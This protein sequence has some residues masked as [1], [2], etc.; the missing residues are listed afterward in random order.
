MNLIKISL[1][2]IGVHAKCI[3]LDVHAS[4]AVVMSEVHLPLCLAVGAALFLDFLL[5]TMVIPIFPSMLPKRE[6][7]AGILFAAKPLAQVACNPLAAWLDNVV[8]LR[9][10]T[11]L[12][13]VG[14]LAF[15]VAHGFC[16]LVAIR[17]A[18]GAAS[19]GVM[20]GGMSL[21]LSSHAE[22]ARPQAV[23]R[24]LLGLT[25]GVCLGPVWGGA[26]YSALGRARAFGLTSLAMFAVAAAQRTLLMGQLRGTPVEQEPTDEA[27]V[28]ERLAGN[29]GGRRTSTFRVCDTRL[30]AASAAML[31][32]SAQ[33][34]ALEV[35]TTYSLHRRFHLE[36]AQR[37]LL[38]AF[39]V[40]GCHA[41][42]TAFVA[43]ADRRC[44]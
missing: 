4:G 27:D 36:T 40:P 8:A 37:G 35:V 24:A 44:R 26:A 17:V 5:V 29:A 23:S 43:W 25:T 42:S 14:A 39:T 11:L 33:V 7:H 16:T 20:T 15:G 31:I 32:V 38:W 41:L 18:Q 9:L 28:V 22:D 30:L 1:R 19:A 6:L 3:Y 2:Q 12:G 10:G 34:G 13:A 21:L